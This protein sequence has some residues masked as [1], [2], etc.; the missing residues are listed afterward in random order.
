MLRVTL[1]ALT[2]LMLI[3]CSDKARVQ[4]LEEKVRSQ[5]K[6]LLAQTLAF[7]ELNEIKQSA[8]QE[9]SLKKK[10]QQLPL[11]KQFPDRAD[12]FGYNEAKLSLLSLNVI[13]A[14]QDART[15]ADAQAISMLWSIENIWPDRLSQRGQQYKAPYWK[16]RDL[17][18]LT[19]IGLEGKIGAK[20]D[21]GS[22]VGYGKI[23]EMLSA[24]CVQ[25]LSS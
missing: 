14:E 12:V 3:G 15:L 1:L 10:A 20:H 9:S 7:N 5:E 22:L 18:T 19:R 2:V 17:V 8:T 23:I 11:W 21:A 6:Q 24:D 16:C 4:A 25:A 13:G